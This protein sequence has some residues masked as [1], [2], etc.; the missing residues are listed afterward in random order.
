LDGRTHQEVVTIQEVEG[1]HRKSLRDA[2]FDAL[3]HSKASFLIPEDK[4]RLF[5][6]G[7]DLLRHNSLKLFSQAFA[8]ACLADDKAQDR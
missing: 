5:V 7:E 1:S 4:A 8:L 3:P 2:G 6:Q